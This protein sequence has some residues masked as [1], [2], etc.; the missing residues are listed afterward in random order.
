M[1]VKVH[2]QVHERARAGYSRVPSKRVA[3]VSRKVFCGA[4]SPLITGILLR[5]ERLRAA[6]LDSC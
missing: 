2:V 4:S 3:M 5:V 1:C 6:R